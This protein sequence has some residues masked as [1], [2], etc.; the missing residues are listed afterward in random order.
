LP[1][2]VYRKNDSEPNNVDFYRNPKIISPKL[3]EVP[4]TPDLFASSNVDASCEDSQQFWSWNLEFNIDRGDAIINV[5]FIYDNYPVIQQFNFKKISAGWDT[6]AE[7]II[8]VPYITRENLH[9]VQI[10]TLQAND[11][12]HNLFACIATTIEKNGFRTINYELHLY[13]DECQIID[14][15]IL[16]DDNYIGTI[17]NGQSRK[18]CFFYTNG[19]FSK[20]DLLDI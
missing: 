5:T 2:L 13:L 18:L 20:C 12:I 17:S 14:A 7:A 4:S 1:V 8:D 9:G 10:G 3:K 19:I 16:K 15:H 6:T 11:N